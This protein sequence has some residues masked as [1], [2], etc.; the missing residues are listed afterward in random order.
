MALARSARDASVAS[1][2][3]PTSHDPIKLFGYQHTAAGTRVDCTCLADASRQMPSRESGVNTPSHDVLASRHFCQPPN[4]AAWISAVR[5]AD[6]VGVGCV[7]LILGRR[8]CESRG[9]PP[10]PSPDDW[11]AGPARRA[12]TPPAVGGPPS[13]SRNTGGQQH[14]PPR[15]ACHG[16]RPR[17]HAA[18][19]R[20]PSRVVG[21]GRLARVTGE[22]VTG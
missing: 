16:T 7:A 17:P 18:P 3:K 6:V 1:N 2:V 13:R 21:L 12:W 14:A 8:R 15:M 9:Q 19:M 11:R 10:R 4:A 5:A 20:A 22:S